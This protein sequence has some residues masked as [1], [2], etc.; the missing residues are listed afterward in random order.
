LNSGKT[1]L[2]FKTPLARIAHNGV[3]LRA[4]MKFTRTVTITQVRRK[5]ALGGSGLRCPR[6]GYELPAQ[7]EAEFP[8]KP[9]KLPP[10]G[11]K[12]G[13]GK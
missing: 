5:I 9:R 6:C 7:T 12:D 10:P 8:E 13:T 3:A 1:K 2:L 11:K 4:F